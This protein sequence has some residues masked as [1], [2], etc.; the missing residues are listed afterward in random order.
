MANAAPAQGSGLFDYFSKLGIL[1]I[2]I[3]F[4]PVFPR[5]C[6]LLPF[7]CCFQFRFIF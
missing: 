6:S 5:F 1:D 4:F 3:V 2:F 7:A